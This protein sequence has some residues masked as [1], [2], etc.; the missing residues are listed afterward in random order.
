LA[1]ALERFIMTLATAAIG[2]WALV[3]G[4]SYFILGPERAPTTDDPVPPGA[5]PTQ[6]DRALARLPAA[7]QVKLYNSGN[8]FD[9]LAIPP[10]DYAAIAQ[11]LRGFDNVIVENHP[12]MCTS[13][14]LRFR[15]LLKT[16]LEVALGLETVHA[17][18]LAALNK[19]MTVGDFDRAARF[20]RDEGIAVRAFILL[21]LPLLSEEE[22]IHWALASVVHAFDAG[23][24]C[25]SIIP[26]RAGNGIMERLARDGLFAPPQLASLERVLEEG[27]ALRRGR[28]FVDLWD[29]QRLAACSRCGPE[30]I[31]R[32]RQMNLCQQV[33]PQIDCDCEAAR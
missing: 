12:R 6:I 27:I 16:G 22:G 1:L 7:Q 15:D 4:L 8:F 17:E 30:R 19:R 23:A 24:D 20:L 26:T 3:D 11:R 2:A 10:E 18:A 13:D 25:C 21:R 14:C 29:A 31:E 32:L 28:V 5:I 9:P 33:L